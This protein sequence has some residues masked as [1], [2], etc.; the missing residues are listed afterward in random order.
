MS[1]EIR[2]IGGRWRSRRLR[3]V[4]VAGLRPTPDRVRETLFNWLQSDIPQARVLDLF[5]GSGA[6][7]FEA[8]SRGATSVILVERDRRQAEQLRA[9]VQRLEAGD[10]VQVQARDVL[11]WL[12]ET[13]VQ[14]V[15]V[16]FMD[17]PY[18]QNLAAQTAAQLQQS[19][20]LRPGQWIYAETEVGTWAWPATW[21]CHRET[22]A[23]LVCGR[24]FEVMD[25]PV[26]SG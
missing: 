14:A 26:T 4:P 19:G 20:W 13:P 8:A 18:H 10:V 3:F 24:L 23:G 1:D 11:Q 25:Q 2:I 22:R 6:L 21:R 15:D 5:S 12:A 7:G 16:V 9:N 17:P